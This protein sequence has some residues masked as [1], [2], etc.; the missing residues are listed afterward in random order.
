MR[1][2]ASEIVA[3][4]RYGAVGMFFYDPQPR[5]RL[6]VLLVRDVTPEEYEAVSRKLAELIGVE[7]FDPTTFQPE[8]LMFWPS[9]CFDGEFFFDCM[10]GPALDPDE[11]LAIAAQGTPSGGDSES[12]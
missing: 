5:I 7:V 3:C 6:V 8:R 11:Y 1:A 9:V 10:D 12:L 4:T 2:V